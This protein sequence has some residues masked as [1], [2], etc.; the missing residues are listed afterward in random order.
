MLQAIEALL[1]TE[2]FDEISKAPINKADLELD[3][4]MPLELGNA[5]EII[6]KHMAKLRNSDFWNIWDYEPKEEDDWSR[7]IWR[8]YIGCFES[9]LN[10]EEVFAIASAST[11]NKF[12]RDNNPARYLWA[13]VKR[14]E[15]TAINLQIMAAKST[16]E[17][18]EMIPGDEFKFKGKSF[19]DHYVAWGKRPQTHRH[20]ITNLELSSYSRRCLRET[21]DL[22]LL[23][24]RLNL[25]CGV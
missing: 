25:T 23:G 16:F 19:I 7:L 1:P 13:D 21:S 12:A 6:I 2:I 17:M 3:R 18:P 11:V 5:Q 20:N 4:T 8:L 9:G 24:V 10:A 15:S 22:K 14:A